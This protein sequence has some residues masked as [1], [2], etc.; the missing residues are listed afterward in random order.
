LTRLREKK[1]R[2]VYCTHHGSRPFFKLIYMF[3]DYT[4]PEIHNSD[5]RRVLYKRNVPEVAG[6]GVCLARPPGSAAFSKAPRPPVG[7][8]QRQDAPYLLEFVRW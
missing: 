3:T 7:G 6:L 5:V 4:I 2:L 1:I 8:R